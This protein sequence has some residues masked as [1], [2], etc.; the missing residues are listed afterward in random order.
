MA[1]KTNDAR[2]DRRSFLKLAGLGSVAG[3]AALV[4]GTDK[5]AAADTAGSKGAGYKE[6][7][8]VKTFYQSARF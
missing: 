1:G 3:G 5:A 6:T 4:A 2:T 8:Q 7:E